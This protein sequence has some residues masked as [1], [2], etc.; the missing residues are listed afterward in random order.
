MTEK[1][2]QAYVRYQSNQA[3]DIAR[4]EFAT[5]MKL[6]DETHADAW[7]GGYMARGDQ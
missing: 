4:H 1:Q 3:A 2:F 5:E 7:I 6:E